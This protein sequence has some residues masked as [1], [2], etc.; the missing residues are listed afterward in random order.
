MTDRYLTA[1]TCGGE[2]NDVSLNGWQEV[3]RVAEEE[4][5]GGFIELQCQCRLD[6]FTV[7]FGAQYIHRKS[8]FACEHVTSFP[9][10]RRSFVAQVAQEYEGGSRLSRHRFFSLSF[11]PV[12][13]LF[14]FPLVCQLC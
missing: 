12:C 2:T 3:P 11:L 9:T 6:R 10:C 5:W 14:S 7:E 4:G 1:R 13:F 8:S